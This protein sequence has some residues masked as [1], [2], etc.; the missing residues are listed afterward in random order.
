MERIVQQVGRP[1]RMVLVFVHQI[2]LVSSVVMMMVAVANAKHVRMQTR[3]AIPPPGSANLIFVFLQKVLLAT[4]TPNLAVKGSPASQSLRIRRIQS[5]TRIV[6]MTR[7]FVPAHSSALA[8]W[9][10]VLPALR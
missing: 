1:A 4:S 3:P 6:Q 2:A 9:R 5:A 8:G 10:V 7:Q